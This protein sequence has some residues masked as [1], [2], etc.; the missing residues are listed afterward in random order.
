M[1]DNANRRLLVRTLNRPISILGLRRFAQQGKD[2]PLFV[3]R[4]RVSLQSSIRSGRVTASLT[5]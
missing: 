3:Q 4:V 5:R 1:V 2:F